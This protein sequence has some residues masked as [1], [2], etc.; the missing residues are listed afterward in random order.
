MKGEDLIRTE[1]GGIGAIVASRWSTF[2]RNFL[3]VLKHQK[4]RL[5]LVLS[6]RDLRACFNRTLGNLEEEEECGTTGQLPQLTETVVILLVV[7]PL[8]TVTMPAGVRVT[9]WHEI[10]GLCVCRQLYRTGLLND[11]LFEPPLSSSFEP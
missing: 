11:L 1:S 7:S 6:S 9:L 5:C 8:L 2:L 3:L 4:S 10:S